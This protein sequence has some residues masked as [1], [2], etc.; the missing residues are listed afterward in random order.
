[1]KNGFVRKYSGIFEIQTF[2][3]AVSDKS[4]CYVIPVGSRRH[5]GK[6]DEKLI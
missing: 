2:S 5:D 1:M 4:K 3:Q 6:N